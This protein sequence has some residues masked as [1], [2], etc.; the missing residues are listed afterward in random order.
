VP[1]HPVTVLVVDDDPTARTVLYRTM[2]AAG[3]VVYAAADGVEALTMLAH[4]PSVDVVV[5]DVRMPG[6]DGRQL[7]EAVG[8]RYPHI[9]VLFVSGYDSYIGTAEL[10]GPVVSKPFR[11]EALIESVQQVLARQQRFA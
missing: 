4:A 6:M 8:A 1:V 2:E 3:H 11:A 10:P 9:P 5:T 7:A